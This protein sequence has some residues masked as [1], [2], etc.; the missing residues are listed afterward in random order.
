MWSGASAARYTDR[1]M[2]DDK[3][4]IRPAYLLSISLE[5]VRCFGPEQHLDLSC[6]GGR[7][8]QWTLILGDNGT[9]KTT[10]LQLIAGFQVQTVDG[11]DGRRLFLRNQRDEKAPHFLRAD[12]PEL[13]ATATYV[14]GSSL[15]DAGRTITSH[16]AR[17]IQADGIGF[18][19]T[20]GFQT[21]ILGDFFLLG[22]GASR[23]LT[24]TE[25]K[26]SES[27]NT[28]AT[29]FDPDAG[30]LNAEELLLR[31]DYRAMQ[32]GRSGR[33]QQR[34]EQ[35]IEMLRGLLP[36]VSGVRIEP[37]DQDSP[38]RSGLED[39]F[40]FQTP[41][42]EVPLRSL[43]LG[44]QTMI[45]WTV[46]MASRLLDRYPTSASPLHEHAVVLVDEIDLHLHPRW[47]R[48]ILDF[49]SQRFPNVQFIATAHSPLVVQAAGERGVNLAVLRREGDHVVID[50]DPKIVE[51]W[52]VDQILTS[53]LFAGVD[54]ARGP[55]TEQQLLRRRVLLMQSSRSLEEDEELAGLNKHLERLPTASSPEDQRA[56]ELIRRAAA[57]LE[58]RS[59]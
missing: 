5:N 7:P 47:Q 35:V 28:T 19:D 55:Q 58:R 48:Q 52:R 4:P 43:S 11:S 57:L 16:C 8:A 46:D 21:D 49:L 6:D 41:Y 2:T 51:G 45:A 38:L 31:L 33:A 13:T 1:Q 24:G 12:Q 56:M 54:G 18:V 32:S 23:R 42:G 53:E 10:L 20:T 22:Y 39:S 34:L 59:S 25:L 17:K 37:S 50:N 15:A 36:D 30:L 29:L 27:A 26:A 40:R 14:S 9:G 3:T 44:Y